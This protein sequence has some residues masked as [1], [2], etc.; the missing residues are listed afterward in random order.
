VRLPIAAVATVAV[1]AGGS[2]F[3]APANAAT[4][5]TVTLKN[6]VVTITGTAARD[7]IHIGMDAKELVVDFGFDGTIDAR[8]PRSQY[9]KVRVVAGAGDDGVGAV[10]AGDVPLTLSGGAGN[11]S[12]T[13]IDKFGEANA[14]DAPTALSGG[15]GNDNIFAD[16]PGP[17]TI[18]G[19]AGDDRVDGGD[20]DVGPETVS[21]GDGNDRFLC[22]LNT[23]FGVR[24]DNVDG[25]TGQDTMAL[26]GTFATESVGFSAR[27]GH[28]VVSHELRDQIVAATIED[29][30][31]LGFGGLDLGS[32][33]AIAVNDLSGTGVVR[34]TAD[35][36]ADHGST[37]PNNSADTLTVR[38]TPGVDHI[39]VSGS[40]GNVVVSGL[41]P[42]VTAVFVRSEDFLLIDTLQGDDIVDSSGL[43][44]GV[45]QLLVR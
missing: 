7:V 40:N 35:F 25:G 19:G 37:E 10:R 4:L 5:P 16:T 17:V 38:G 23:S 34:F 15:D 21:L 9:H 20:A 41:T 12:L 30:S 24:H 43:Q 45:V 44:P 28:L 42:V 14:N 33:D 39:A 29:V 27:N 8:F 26:T 22:T 18:L 13:V 2:A 36:R 1:L 11:D 6:G 31:Y 32:G 3:A